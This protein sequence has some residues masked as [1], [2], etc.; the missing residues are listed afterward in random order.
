MINANWL[1]DL[2]LLIVS[3]MV[4]DIVSVLSEWDKIIIT[5]N[6]IMGLVRSK[7]LCTHLIFKQ[8]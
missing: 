2:N 3:S 5:A 4:L 6:G 1:N 8:S 7:Y